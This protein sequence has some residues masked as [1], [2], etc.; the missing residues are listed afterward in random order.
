MCKLYLN[1]LKYTGGHWFVDL[2]NR[3]CDIGRFLSDSA[4]GL[5]GNM[6]LFLPPHPLENCTS[7]LPPPRISST[8]PWG[9]GGGGIWMF[10]K[11][12][13]S[14]FHE[15]VNGVNWFLR[16]V[17]NFSWLL[18]MDIKLF[19]KLIRCTVNRLK[20]WLTIENWVSP[21]RRSFTVCLIHLCDLLF[22]PDVWL[23]VNT[24]SNCDLLW[25]PCYYRAAKLDFWNICF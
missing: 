15:G 20:N 3:K 18:I 19:L 9:G 4:L 14:F 7:R 17:D 21:F 1:T 23:Q 11:T 10:S 5:S 12:T 24:K 2:L 16:L 25:Q 6:L 8:I 22:I 13:Y